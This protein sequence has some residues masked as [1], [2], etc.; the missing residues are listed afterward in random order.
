M[1]W[2]RSATTAAKIPQ[3]P[4]PSLPGQVRRV[5]CVDAMELIPPEDW[6]P[7]LERFRRALRPGSWL[8]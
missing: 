8:Y 2:R 7:V 6:P 3:P 5:L 1:A 4:G